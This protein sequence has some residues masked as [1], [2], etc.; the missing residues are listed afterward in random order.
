M[1]L[2]FWLKSILSLWSWGLVPFKGEIIEIICWC[3]S[4]YFSQKGRKSHIYI[5][6]P[7]IVQKN[8]LKIMVI[9]GQMGPQLGKHFTYAYW[10]NLIQ[11]QE[12]EVN[13]NQTWW[14][15]PCMKGIHVCFGNKH[16]LALSFSFFLISVFIIFLMHIRHS[17]IMYGFS[18][19]FIFNL[20]AFH[21]SSCFLVDIWHLESKDI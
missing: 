2:K 20:P 11:N 3:L 16:D 18:W 14:K 10:K 9:G 12:R 19:Y 6:L 4:R 21:S 1:I 5:K 8:I 15:Y 13:F 17:S 7:R